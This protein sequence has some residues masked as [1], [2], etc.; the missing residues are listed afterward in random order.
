VF[1][2]EVMKPRR[3][4]TRES[5]PQSTANQ[6]TPYLLIHDNRR[7]LSKSLADMDSRLRP[8]RAQNPPKGLATRRKRIRAP[9]P[10][11]QPDLPPEIWSQIFEMLPRDPFLKR[12]LARV[13]R[14][15]RAWNDLGIRI[16]FS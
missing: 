9:P 7:C 15:C 14:T 10:E 6:A 8:R 11:T 13:V 12:E 5:E 4:N 1:L 16:L 2:N 3:R